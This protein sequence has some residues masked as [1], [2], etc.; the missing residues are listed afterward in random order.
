MQVRS[1]TRDEVARYRTDGVVYL[2][3]LVDDETTMLLLAEA[4]RRR[5]NPGRYSSHLSR[6][7]EFF[8][9]RMCCRE[10]DLFR[11]FVLES[12]MGKA[13]APCMATSEVRFFFDHLFICGPNTPTEYYWHQDLSYWPVRGNKICSVW[14]A[15]T[16]CDPESSALQLV[17]R[18]HDGPLHGV[19]E[20]G[21]SEDYD[22]ATERSGGDRIPEYHL[23]PDAHGIITRDVKAGDA[24]LFHAKTMHASGGNRSKD[25]RRV[26]YS[27]RWT[28]DDVRWQPNPVFTDDAIL[29][30]A[31]DL[32]VGGP[33][34]SPSF[35]LVWTS[36]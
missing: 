2:P 15:L 33:L 30:A 20:F 24:Y 22:G 1:L 31:P 18:T 32:A 9:E 12:G 23:N 19:R 29:H 36:R 25:R 10:S 5:K 16:D 7:G 17:P 4:D 6:S 34:D 8:E 28:G 14:L 13:V 21:D 26:A 11:T 27:T 3:R 35:P